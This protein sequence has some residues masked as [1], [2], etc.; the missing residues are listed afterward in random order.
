MMGT[1]KGVCPMKIVTLVENTSCRPDLGAEHGLSLYLEIGSRKVLF[2]S[3]QTGLLA[4][5]AEKLGVDL[6]QV[7]TVILSHGHYDHG[8]GLFTFM[9]LNSSAPIYASDSCFDDYYNGTKKYIGLNPMLRD[10]RRFRLISEITDLGDGMTLTPGRFVLTQH[11]VPYQGLNVRHKSRYCP[12]CFLHEQYLTVRE[13][14]KT[15]LFSGCSHRGILNIAQHFQ[16][17]VLIGGFHFKKLDPENDRPQ[18]VSSAKA[19]LDLP[20]DYYTCHCT[21]QAQYQVLKQVMGDRISYL[22]AGSQLEL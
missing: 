21:G 22:S 13:Q 16:P 17:D 10:S 7:D 3:G 20:T 14:G 8:G 12:D 5:N 9:D 2:D 11:K 15:V 6:S 1:G 18:L 19:L 4:E